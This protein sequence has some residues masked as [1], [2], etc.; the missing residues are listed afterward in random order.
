MPIAKA[1]IN[2][3]WFKPGAVLPFNLRVEDVRH[4]MQ[5]IYDF[6]YDVNSFLRDRALPRLEETVR[7]AIFSGMLSDIITTSL[8]KHSRSLTPNLYHNGHPDLI[9]AGEYEGNSVKAGTKGVEVKTTGKAGG[10]VDFHGARDQW[11]AVFVYRV[12]AITEPHVNRAP[13]RF[14]EVYVSHV[15]ADDFRRNERSE[16]GTRTATIDR[17]GLVRFREGWLYKEQAGPYLLRT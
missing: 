8:A 10:A 12:D 15:V 14:T 9:V 4:T 13:T 11:L 16:L 5:D 17:Y 6:L 7:P 3:D 1:Q 2:D